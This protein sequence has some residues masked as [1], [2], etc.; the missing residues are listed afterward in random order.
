MWVEDGMLK[1]SAFG[2][3]EIPCSRITAIRKTRNILMLGYPQAK[4][5]FCMV[6]HAAAGV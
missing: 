1:C 3:S 2:Y 4:K 6:S 5:T